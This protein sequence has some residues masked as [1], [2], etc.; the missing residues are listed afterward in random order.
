MQ[1][2]LSGGS[3]GDNYAIDFNN[4]GTAERSA[5]V[6]NGSISLNDIPINTTLTG[7]YLT[8]TRNACKAEYATSNEFKPQPNL[9]ITGVQFI[10]PNGCSESGRIEIQLSGTNT[11]DEFEVD[12]NNDGAIDGTGITGSGL[13]TLSPVLAGT[14]VNGITLRHT[15]SG[16]VKFTATKGVIPLPIKPDVSI[17][18]IQ[19][20]CPN[21]LPYTLEGAAPAGGN[22][23]VNG[24]LSTTIDPQQIN[25]VNAE[26]VYEYTDANNCTNTDTTHVVIKELPETGLTGEQTTCPEATGVIYSVNYNSQNLYEWAIT[27]GSYTPGNNTGTIYVDWTD[28]YQ[29]EVKVKVTDPTTQ[30]TDSSTMEVQLV[31]N[32]PPVLYDCDAVLHFPAVSS[33]SMQRT[34]VF[35]EADTIYLPKAMDLCS[36]AGITIE[37]SMDDGSMQPISE[38]VGSRLTGQA[39]HQIYWQSVDRAGNIGTCITNVILDFDL[40]A[41]GAFSPNGDEIN[42]TWELSFLVEYPE[43]VVQVYNRWGMLVYESEK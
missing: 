29:G 16:C 41:P 31:D 28:T 13:V 11:A 30:C 12:L 26:V 18:D 5:N 35:T 14:S 42:D 38:F 23:Y 36:P 8:N 19:P 40:V 2:M 1:I 37:F 6:D 39:P 24:V 34:Y 17:P 15:Q 43:C 7:I 9:Q 4:D 27:N 25:Q 22:Y 32:N 33:P 20:L 21:S 10:N 3:N